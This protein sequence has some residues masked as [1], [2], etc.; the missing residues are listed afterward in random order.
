MDSRHILETKKHQIDANLANLF[1]EVGNA[2]DAAIK[3]LVKK[4]RGFA[5]PSSATTST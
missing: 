1:D 2:I 5:R 3:C 4:D